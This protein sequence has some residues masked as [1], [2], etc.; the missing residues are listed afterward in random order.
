MIR[1]I[2][3]II[4]TVTL[5]SHVGPVSQMNELHPRLST[6]QTEKKSGG[7]KK[8]NSVAGGF[9]DQPDQPDWWNLSAKVPCLFLELLTVTIDPEIKGLEIVYTATVR[10]R[11]K[12]T[13]D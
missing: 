7:T 1:P 4:F 2:L 5:A 6:L 9:A 11:L 3:R 8:K 13:R 12:K 10:N